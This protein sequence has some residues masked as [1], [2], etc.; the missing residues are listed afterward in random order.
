[1]SGGR[2]QRPGE[3]GEGKRGEAAGDRRGFHDQTDVERM[4]IDQIGTET[5]RSMRAG[6]RVARGEKIPPRRQPSSSSCRVT[7]GD[8][9]FCGR[10]GPP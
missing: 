8:A 9:C 1:V 10:F 5:V 2:D 3:Q 6:M 4:R 7:S